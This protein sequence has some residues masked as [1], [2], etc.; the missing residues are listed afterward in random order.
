MYGL[1]HTREKHLLSFLEPSTVLTQN[2]RRDKKD[3][4][5]HRTSS[6][7]GEVPEKINLLHN[8]SMNLS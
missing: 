5:E 7:Y 2:Y 1:L 8:I 4:K 3:L 6:A